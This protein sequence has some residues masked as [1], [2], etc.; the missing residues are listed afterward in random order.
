MRT[1]LLLSLILAFLLPTFAYS[2]SNEANPGNSS[3]LVCEQLQVFVRNGCPYCNQAKL[4]LTDLQQKYPELQ[5]LESNVETNPAA[6]AQFV[7]LNEA[8]RIRQPGVPT[9]SFCGEILVGFSS[10]EITGTIIERVLTGEQETIAEG[11]TTNLPVL[12]NVNPSVLGLPLFTVIIGLVDGFNP[13]AMWI[14]LFL[15]SL[16][17]HVKQRSRIIMVAGTFVMVSGLVYF[18]FMAAW[19][20]VF[21]L[22]GFS[23][24]LQL[25]LG[26]FAVLIGVVHVKD[27][28]LLGRGFSLSIPEGVKPSIYERARRVVQAENLGAAMAGVTVIA[29]LVNF[30]ELLCTAGLPALYT[31]VLTYYP[32]SMAGYYGY[33]LLYNL[34]YIVDDALMVTLAVVTLRHHKLQEN[35]GRWLKLISGSV[36]LLLGSL[37]IFAPNLLV[38]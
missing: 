21:L 22:I 16:L 5:V 12:G 2:Q 30:V 15:L 26:A 25:L 20:N 37:L 7:G 28:F 31:Q 1:L 18:A 11:L 13:C 23:R 14:L 27:F 34:A 33:L 9:F 29:I 6:L 10:R 4:F 8:R 36:I 38:F 35:Q 24:A 32:L 3:G 17:V 19:F